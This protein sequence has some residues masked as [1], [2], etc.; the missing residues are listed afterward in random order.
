[1]VMPLVL[2]GVTE[3]Q[4]Q[5][6]AV[7]KSVLVHPG[8]EK[9]VTVRLESAGME[10]IKKPVGVVVTVP[11]GLARLSALLIMLAE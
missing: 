8:V 3:G 6:G 1:M 7:T 5:L 4:L 9:V 2:G 10:L 11:N